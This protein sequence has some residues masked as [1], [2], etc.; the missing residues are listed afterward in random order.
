MRVVE[1]RAV[2]WTRDEY[3]RMAE[4]GFFLGR[5]VELIKGEV[6]E[7]SPQD[8]GHTTAVS[9]LD[10]LFKAAFPR[11]WVVRIQSPLAL[12]AESDP[13]PDIAVVK[14]SPR[15]FVRSQPS[16]AALVIEVASSSLEYDRTSKASLYA[17]A[18]IQD[19]WIVDLIER[20]LEVY[21]N[22]RE[23]ETP[24]LGFGYADRMVLEAG[25]SVSPLAL[26]EARLLVADMLP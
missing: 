22:P 26:P 7:M 17:E 25:E 18:G 2:R 23:G 10:Y 4:V 1:P 19:Y 16:T 14:G 8:S 21:R 13:E 9:L 11:G 24:S 5:K 15:D 3:Y 12:G 6:I 20:R